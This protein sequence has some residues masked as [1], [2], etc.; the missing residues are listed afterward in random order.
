MMNEQSAP[1]KMEDN[2]E[3][4]RNG[5]LID[6]PEG[7]CCEDCGQRFDHCQCPD[8]HGFVSPAPPEDDAPVCLACHDTGEFKGGYYSMGMWQ[9]YTRPCGDCAA[10]AKLE[11]QE[12]DDA[13]NCLDCGK[14]TIKDE[15]YCRLCF[16]GPGNI[17][18]EPG[19]DAPDCPICK[20]VHDPPCYWCHKDHLATV[21]DDAKQQEKWADE[22]AEEE[23]QAEQETNEER[24]ADERRADTERAY[25]EQRAQNE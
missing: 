21:E 1:V 7:G 9:T 17:P 14:P 15:T 8:E 18:W 25:E 22:Q 10:R 11:R 12:H 6:Y 5:E 2:P 19:D 23:W 3:N 16:Y 13:R 24:Q 4:Y 20:V